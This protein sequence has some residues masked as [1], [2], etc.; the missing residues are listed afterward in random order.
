VAGFAELAS[1]NVVATDVAI[2]GD[3]GFLRKVNGAA[4]PEGIETVGAIGFEE[5]E[6]ER[7]MKGAMI[8][9]MVRRTRKRME[10]SIIEVAELK[11]EVERQGVNFEGSG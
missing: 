9:K 8:Q 7:R 4:A 5:R 3:E 11:E 10:N 2:E 6:R 1:H